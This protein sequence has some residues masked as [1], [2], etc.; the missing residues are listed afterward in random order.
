VQNLLRHRYLIWLIIAAISGLM[1]LRIFTT[2]IVGPHSWRQT[3]TVAGIEHFATGSFNITQPQTYQFLQGTNTLRME[4]PLLQWLIGGAY[5]LFGEHL[6]LLRACMFAV[7]LMTVFGMGKLAQSFFRRDEGFLIASWTLCFS[8]L[9]YYYCINPLPD[10]LALC[11]SVWGLAYFFQ[12]NVTGEIKHLI[13]CVAL[14]ALGTLCK[15]PFIVFYGAFAG[16]LVNQLK[17]RSV[18]WTKLF[19]H[20][21]VPV[22]SLVGP[23]AWYMIVMREWT[24]NIV[25]SGILESDLTAKQLL[26]II[27]G[28]LVSTLPE[29]I[30]NYA[31]VPLF[32][33]ALYFSLR[34][35]SG[36]N[37]QRL[38]FLF[39]CLSVLFYYVFEINAITLIHDYYLFPFLPVLFLLVT[40]GALQ[41]IDLGKKFRSALIVLIA[42]LPVTAFLRADSRWNESDPGFNVDLI[43]YKEQLRAATPAN[44]RIV[45]GND[46][47][48]HI[49]LYYTRHHGWNFYNDKLTAAEL[50]QMI[51]DS[52]AFLY[53][54]S[55]IIESDPLL[56]PYFGDT[57]STFGSFRIITLKM[58]ALKP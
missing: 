49:S 35:K 20:L 34:N 33:I 47:S 21:A 26:D 2:D 51:A 12:W 10:L 56:H 25:T 55:H 1:H 42:I 4:F 44:A 9:F 3:Q 48:A 11:F 27:I 40:Y 23:V 43:T 15:L 16:Y 5:R 32:L 38:P 41:L 37:V 13:A 54:D 57:V 17:S 53:S 39:L 22:L 30:L 29:L 52:A 19:L 50:E 18:S 6:W 28:T 31:A 24:P 46:Q 8:P 36:S 45:I 14:L 58:P 7:G